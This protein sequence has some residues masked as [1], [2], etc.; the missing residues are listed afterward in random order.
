V[1]QSLGDENSCPVLNH[2]K[3]NR[4]STMAGRGVSPDQVDQLNGDKILR[5][6]KRAPV[7]L[8]VVRLP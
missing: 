8:A 6:T 7:R 3:T 1:W 2:P 4:D 5:V